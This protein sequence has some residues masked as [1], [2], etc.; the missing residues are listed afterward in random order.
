M[1]ME[2]ERV[3]SLRGIF[4]RTARPTNG[5]IELSPFDGS[6]PPSPPP[7]SSSVEQQQGQGQQQGQQSSIVASASLSRLG[8]YRTGSFG[9]RS[10][11][12]VVED[13]S[14]IQALI[15]TLAE[16]GEQET[17]KSQ[18]VEALVERVRELC[19]CAE[20]LGKKERE[21]ENLTS[22]LKELSETRADAIRLKVQTL[23]SY[24][25]LQ[26]EY[27]KVLKTTQLAHAVS[28]S[29][30]SRANR[31]KLELAETKK[32]LRQ[33]TQQ[34]AS[35]QQRNSG[36]RAENESLRRMLVALERLAYEPD[37]RH[38]S[39]LSVKQENP[40]SFLY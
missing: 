9:R 7:A 39:L 40:R 25:T 11:K 10:S 17:L 13:S 12:A 19:E 6:K 1:A 16:I 24:H 3:S 36:L 35:L 26:A 20:Q 23:E 29:N 32:Q 4:E 31:L 15:T 18:C 34:T 28:R 27:S 2:G 14:E 38:S 5:P 37:C 30:C 22:V 33:Q 8:S 21:N